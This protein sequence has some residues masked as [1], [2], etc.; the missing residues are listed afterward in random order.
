MPKYYNKQTKKFEEKGT[1]RGTKSDSDIVGKTARGKEV[2]RGEKKKA[3][4]DFKK[5]KEK[6]MANIASTKKSSSKAGMASKSGSSS[7]SN[8]LGK[9]SKKFNV[10]VSKG[11]VSFKEAFRHFRN[12][13]DKTFTWNGKKYTTELKK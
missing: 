11:G 6:T 1:L 9:P 4:A 5:M 8:K 2:T 3:M 10:G 12:K 7:S 13:G